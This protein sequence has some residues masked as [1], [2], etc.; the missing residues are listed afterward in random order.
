MKKDGG[1]AFPCGD[2][3]VFINRKLEEEYGPSIFGFVRVTRREATGMTLRQWYA[4]MAMQ[5]ML[6]NAR[7]LETLMEEKLAPSVMIDRTTKTSYLFADAMLAFEEK[8]AG[9]KE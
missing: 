4:G 1:P 6:A 7:I 5:G 3:D 9:E 2:A 8:E